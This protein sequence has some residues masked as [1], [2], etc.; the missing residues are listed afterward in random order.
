VRRQR[1]KAAPQTPKNSEVA[2]ARGH[3]AEV[4]FRLPCA[5][6]RGAMNRR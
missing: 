5:L 3:A 2:A 6:G 1:A 4:F